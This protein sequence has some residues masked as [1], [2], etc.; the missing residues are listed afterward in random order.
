MGDAEVGVDIPVHNEK[1]LLLV[2][3]DSIPPYPLNKII[4]REVN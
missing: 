3:T 2:S 4:G 1:P